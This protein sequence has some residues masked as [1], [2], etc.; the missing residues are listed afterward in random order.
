M[1]GYDQWSGVLKSD[2]YNAP[3]DLS[4]ESMLMQNE[5][6]FEQR[7]DLQRLKKCYHSLNDENICGDQ[8]DI[9][10]FLC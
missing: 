2:K 4:D 9:I 10:L 1:A 6:E 3:F 7:N 5:I 8:K